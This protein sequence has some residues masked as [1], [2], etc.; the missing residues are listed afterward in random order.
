MPKEPRK[1][2]LGYPWALQERLVIVFSSCV[3]SSKIDLF[4]FSCPGPAQGG[5]LR[6][7][8]C[9]MVLSCRRNARFLEK[10]AFRLHESSSQ[11]SWG[12]EVVFEGVPW[13]ALGGSEVQIEAHLPCENAVFRKSRGRRQK[14]P[15][16]PFGKLESP[17]SGKTVLKRRPPRTR[18]EPLG[19][20]FTFC[21]FLMSF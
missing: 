16:W 3:F 11:P 1:S 5:K 21:T 13:A 17:R 8:R 10:R 7:L 6:F 19:S 14:L 12:S 20:P 9:W 2:C 15:F 18:F 4:P